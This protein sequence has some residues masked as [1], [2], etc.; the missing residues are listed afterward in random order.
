MIYPNNFEKKI[1]FDEIRELLKGYCLSNLGR[2]MVDNITFSNDLTDITEKFEQIKEF[3]R[4]EES[5]E[6]FPTDYFFDVRDSIKRIRLEGTHMEEEELFNLRRSLQ[7][8]T[9]IIT[10]LNKDNSQNGSN[11]N[12][13][14]NDVTASDD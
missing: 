13:K 10:F 14:N 2:E 7:S 12:Y 9:D 6:N 5:G 3:K 8:A 11:K 4:I 1:G